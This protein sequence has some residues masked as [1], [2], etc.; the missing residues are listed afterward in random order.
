MVGSR[1]DS[2]INRIRLSEFHS[3]VRSQGARRWHLSRMAPS[4]QLSC[5]THVK[6]L[7]AF[8]HIS[9]RTLCPPNFGSVGTTPRVSMWHGVDAGMELNRVRHVYCSV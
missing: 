1:K 8:S 5:L 7:C 9:L 2:I 6:G 4:C 3:S